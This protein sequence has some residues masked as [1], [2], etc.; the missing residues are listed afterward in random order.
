[1]QKIDPSLVCEPGN[2]RIR[3]IGR[4]GP[5][6]A[7]RV[8]DMQITVHEDQTGGTVT[9]LVGT[10]ADQAALQGLLDHLYAR[11]HAL[12]SVQ[13]LESAGDGASA[14]A[15]GRGDT[16]DGAPNETR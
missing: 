8:G 5:R 9:D 3:V 11:G 10:V 4:L 6:W 14:E 15:R 16:N 1:M 13:R 7:D 12:L 2:Y